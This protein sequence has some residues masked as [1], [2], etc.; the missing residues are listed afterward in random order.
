M[1]IVGKTVMRRIMVRND[2]TDDISNLKYK[3][4]DYSVLNIEKFLTMETKAIIEIE[5]LEK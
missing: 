2:D 4:F 1:E 5:R 3:H